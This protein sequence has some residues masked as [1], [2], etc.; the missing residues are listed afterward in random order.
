MRTICGQYRRQ[1]DTGI[2][3]NALENTM[4]NYLTI[5]FVLGVIAFASVSFLAQADQQSAGGAM[6]QKAAPADASDGSDA[7][8]SSNATDPSDGE[9]AADKAASTDD[10]KGDKFAK[11][12]QECAQSSSAPRKDGSSPTDS[13]MN[14]A[15]RRC[16]QMDGHSAAEMKAAGVDLTDK[17]D[18]GGAKTGNGNTQ[19]Q[20]APT[21]E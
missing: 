19:D 12:D 4:K 15:Y 9:A 13:E 3:K 10:S 7:S 14:H 5:A 16:M 11:D 20:G 21:D 1:R 6:K 18:K 2:T 17:I 8:D